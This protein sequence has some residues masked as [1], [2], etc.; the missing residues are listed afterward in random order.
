MGG[1]VDI[2]GLCVIEDKRHKAREQ[3]SSPHLGREE[4]GAAEQSVSLSF[5]AASS[6]G[7]QRK[8]GPKATGTGVLM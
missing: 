3:G 5:P 1:T 6:A 2:A 7:G 4:E 8:P